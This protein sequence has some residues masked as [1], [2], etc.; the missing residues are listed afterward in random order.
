M[1]E[2]IFLYLIYAH[3]LDASLVEDERTNFLSIPLL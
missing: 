1:T 2:I 3:V